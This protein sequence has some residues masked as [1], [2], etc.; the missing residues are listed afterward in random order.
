MTD[1]TQGF[2]RL[3]AG[4]M[5]WG[6]WGKKYSSRQMQ[7]LMEHC[8]E[9]GIHT[10][11]H[12][13]IYGDYST[14]EDFGKALAESS[15]DREEIELVSKCGIQM[16]GDA[17]PNR[18]KHYN[19]TRDYIVESA[20]RSLKLL[21]TDYL[22][23]YLLH[24]PSPLMDPEVIAAAVDHLQ[25]RGM[26]RAF[27]VS[28]F[29]PSQ[30]QLLDKATPVMANQV[31]CSL[32]DPIAMFD[33]TLDD[34]ISNN[35]MAMAWSPLG[36]FFREEQSN[37]TALKEQ[38]EKLKEKYNASSTQLLLAWILKHPAKIHPVIGTTRKERISEANKALSLELDLEDWFLLLE[39]SRGEEVP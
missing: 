4:A 28:N 23:L 18:V 36:D 38:L 31:A 34:C 27:G 16:L 21:K 2:S 25:Q 9:E 30:V 32:T 13:D 22:D 39:A 19:Y 14:E 24:R 1:V 12:A 15:I 11:D 7:E 10:F 35:R 37:G 6:S 8:L 17:R 26:I 5:T 20:E 33:G 29:S 3:V